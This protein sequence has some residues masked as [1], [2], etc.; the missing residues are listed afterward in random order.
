MA[1]GDNYVTALGTVVVTAL[2]IG[3]AVGT[4]AL[5]GDTTVDAGA[6]PGSAPA[7]SEVL[8]DDI[9]GL[10]AQLV[11]GTSE[12][13]PELDPTAPDD[14][15]M[16]VALHAYGAFTIQRAQFL[17]AVYHHAIGV[18]SDPELAQ[19][20][21][22]LATVEEVG[23]KLGRIKLDATSAQ[24]E[25]KAIGAFRMSG[26]EKAALAD[27]VDAYAIRDALLTD[28]CGLDLSEG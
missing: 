21:E 10:M 6:T 14:A 24:A 4:H 27:A 25:Y 9:C 20:F 2:A 8:S 7:A 22:T 23:E 26:A 19:A 5:V 13:W 15:D 28:E 11:A 12:P 17:Q 3:A 1:I 18:V 16:V